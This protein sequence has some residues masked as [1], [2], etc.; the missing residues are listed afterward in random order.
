[1]NYQKENIRLCKNHYRDRRMTIEALRKQ[2]SDLQM[3]NTKTETELHTLYA[4]RDSEQKLLK[5][6]EKRI[7][8][9][10]RRLEILKRDVFNLTIEH[11]KK[12]RAKQLEDRKEE[13]KKAISLQPT[14]DDIVQKEMTSIIS[15]LKE[16]N[17][18]IG[19]EI[20]FDELWE[21]YNRLL[22]QREISRASA[23]R[24]EAETRYITQ[25]TS[26]I[27]RELDGGTVDMIEK[28]NL[29]IPIQNFLSNP[30]VKAELRI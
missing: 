8:H 13:I 17:F 25:L 20:S 15:E 26:L 7:S 19:T 10:H 1:M 11:D 16:M 30:I 23:V 24:Q 9:T 21:A 27:E 29:K 6:T 4:K 18:S 22:N 2:I 14:F 12:V 28:R 3:Q 5:E